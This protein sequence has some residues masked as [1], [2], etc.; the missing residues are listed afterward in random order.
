MAPRGLVKLT[1]NQ[2]PKYFLGV[3]LTDGGSISVG[4]ALAR[5]T[6]QYDDRLSVVRAGGFLFQQPAGDPAS[7]KVIRVEGANGN[8]SEK[9]S[10][11]A[12][13]R[14]GGRRLWIMNSDE[15]YWFTPV[16]SA[17][18]RRQDTS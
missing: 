5:P 3:R 17:D 6:E 1:Q 9:K 10:L 18:H 4:Q 14:S 12:R 2:H 8:Q 15:G 7:V 16:S 11:L 13:I